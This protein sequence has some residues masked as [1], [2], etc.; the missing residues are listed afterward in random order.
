MGGLGLVIDIPVPGKFRRKFPVRT[1]ISGRN[2]DESLNAAAFKIGCVDPVKSVEEDIYSLVAVLVT[3]SDADEDRILRH[4]FRRHGGGYLDKLFAGFVVT[5]IVFFIRGRGNAILEPI[6][7]NDIDL[8]A[9]ELF[10][11][12]CGDVTD[13]R[14][15]V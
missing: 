5:D 8:P 1:V 14:K 11:L 6:G 12:T 4:S 10:A 15:D 3:A 9:K 13:G 7:S 2:H